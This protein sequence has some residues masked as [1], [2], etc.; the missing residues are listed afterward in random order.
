MPV[1][2]RDGLHGLMEDFWRGL[3]RSARLILDRELFIFLNAQF[4]KRSGGIFKTRGSPVLWAVVNPA[5]FT[6]KLFGHLT[7][8]DLGLAWD[9]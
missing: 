1:A 6:Q 9:Q 7:G 8:G 2:C 3:Q 4:C 5:G